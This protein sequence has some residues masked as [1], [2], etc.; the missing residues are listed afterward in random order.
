M[1]SPGGL[2]F[3]YLWRMEMK[4][5]SEEAKGSERFLCS[6]QER[7]SIGNQMH[8]YSCFHADPIWGP[9]LKSGRPWAQG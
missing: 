3:C 7:T 4:L 6:K 2:G 9:S 5:K 1:G 8:V